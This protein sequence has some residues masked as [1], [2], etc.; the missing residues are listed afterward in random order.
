MNS[1][2][3]FIVN[4][5]S[6]SPKVSGERKRRKKVK[7]EERD[8]EEKSKRVA[9]PSALS[10]LSHSQRIGSANSSTAKI[11]EKAEFLEELEWFRAAICVLYYCMI[12]PFKIDIKEGHYMLCTNLIQQVISD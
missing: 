5:D 12:V 7:A 1:L 3:S 6:E 4:D 10:R 2:R 9:P 11:P 8:S